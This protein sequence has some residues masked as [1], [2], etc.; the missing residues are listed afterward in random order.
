MYNFVEQNINMQNI[1]VQLNENGDFIMILAAIVTVF[2]WISAVIKCIIRMIRFIIR[3]IMRKKL[4]KAQNEALIG[5]TNQDLKKALKYY[6]STKGQDIDPCIESEDY[7]RNSFISR[8]LID[9]FTENIFKSSEMRY[10]IILADSGMGK[11]TFLLKLFS[12]YCKKIFRKYDIYLIPLSLESSIKFIKEI[13][14]KSNTILLLDAFDEDQYAMKNYDERLKAICNETELFYKVIMTCRTQFFPDSNSEPKYTG[15]LQ[16]GVGNKRVE[17][18]KYYISPF[19]NQEIDEY[20]KNKYKHFLKKDKIDRARKIIATCPNLMI[21]P[22]LLSYIDDLLENKEKNYKYTY[23]V[24]REL[25]FKWINR[26]SVDNDTLYDFSDKVAEY[27]Y[28]NK[29]TY[30]SQNQIEGLCN[31]YNIQLRNIEAKSR[32]LLN[33][34]AIGDYKFAHK[35]ILEYLLAQKAFEDLEFRK[36]I[37]LNESRGYEMTKMFLKEM[38]VAYIQKFL[39]DKFPDLGYKCFSFFQLSNIN[40]SK[41]EMAYCNFEGSNLSNANLSKADLN[42]ANLIRTDLSKANLVDANLIEARLNDAN[43]VGADLSGADLVEAKLSGADLSEAKLSGADLSGADLVEAKLSGADLSG[44]DLE[45][46]IW[47]KSDIP[48][49]L[50]QLKKAKFTYI[51]TTVKDIQ[52]KRY[53]REFFPNEE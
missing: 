52:R 26:E 36:T 32:S 50:V 41:I 33:R 43:L 22:M 17:F 12:T 44:A 46:S 18:A 15:K 16:I 4:K 28:M 11:T 30:I 40:L 35:S 5:F 53:R 23:E 14:N 13:K 29:T 10:F 51:T 20:L 9:L 48:K 1:I 38:N 49:V 8:N 7:V 34:N 6:V 37:I 39:G 31:Q 19:D 42:R 21:R 3:F 45:G 25:V 24:Y 47:L 27:M 2:L